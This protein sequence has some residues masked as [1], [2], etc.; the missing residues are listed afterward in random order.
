ME[1]NVWFK[2]KKNCLKISYI[3]DLENIVGP[4]NKK[5]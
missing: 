1:Y 3:F 2:R 4:Y 5:G